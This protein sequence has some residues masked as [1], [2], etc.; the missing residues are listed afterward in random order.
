MLDYIIGEPNIEIGLT[1]E[2]LIIALK[3]YVLN[4][5][6][7]CNKLEIS[8]SKKTLDKVKKARHY[9]KTYQ[10]NLHI[11]DSIE[12][13]LNTSYDIMNRIKN[14][15]EYKNKLNDLWIKGM[16]HN[17]SFDEYF[18]MHYDCVNL[19]EQANDM[20]SYIIDFKDKEEVER[21]RESIAIALL[22]IGIENSTDIQKDALKN[23]GEYGVKEL[24]STFKHGVIKYYFNSIA[25]KIIAV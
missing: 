16:E 8:L 3:A 7:I 17:K 9:Y 11:K 23:L 5:D 21:N 6:L 22:S 18:I 19:K 2:E 20:Q 14:T 10:D 13:F 25:S 4:I 15:E 24:N 12:S 1:K